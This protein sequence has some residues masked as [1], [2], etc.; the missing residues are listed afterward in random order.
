MN[1]QWNSEPPK[2][3]DLFT[4]DHALQ[5]A[6]AINAINQRY[7][8]KIQSVHPNSI[9]AGRIVYDWRDEIAKT[10]K[11]MMADM[12]R[13][14]DAYRKLATDAVNCNPRVVM[15]IDNGRQPGS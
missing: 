13:Q 7:T 5:L 15:L 10:C 12:S 9:E 4:V 8:D 6:R 3:G 14:V 2:P 11:A 1:E